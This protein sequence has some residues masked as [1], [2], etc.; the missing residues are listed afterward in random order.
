LILFI[1]RF[2]ALI[3]LICLIVFL[4]IGKLDVTS[5]KSELKLE[6][7]NFNKLVSQ[8][9]LDK[10]DSERAI[11]SLFRSRGDFRD[12]EQEFVVETKNLKAEIDGFTPKRLEIE[13]EKHAKSEELKRLEIKLVTTLAPLD[14]I[15]IQKIPLQKSKINKEEEKLKHT[16]VLITEKNDADLKASNF[17]NLETKRTIATESFNEEFVRLMEGIKKPF[18]FYYSESN[19]V[20]IASRA[21]SGKGIFINFGYEDGFRENM[22]FLTK[23]ENASSPLSFRL[24]AKLVQKNFSYLEFLDETQVIDSSFATEG[25]SLILTRSGEIILNESED[26]SKSFLE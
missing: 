3:C 9:E 23:N 26:E 8:M 1:F 21:P 17:Q 24:K 11:S 4:T 6:E 15:S 12:K 20:L 25:Q 22:E 19:E 13:K 5:I 2:L 16:Q 7:S 10:N 14:E 18:H